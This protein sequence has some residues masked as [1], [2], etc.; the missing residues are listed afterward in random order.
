VVRKQ[1]FKRISFLFSCFLQDIAA[2]IKAGF[3]FIFR[4]YCRETETAVPIEDSDLTLAL[5]EWW[6]EGVVLCEL[7]LG[8]TKFTPFL[9]P[10][11]PRIV[12]NRWTAPLPK[13]LR[14]KK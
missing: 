2:E 3:C 1:L 10:L 9:T 11:P 13:L 5:S 14:N 12:T 6:W 8:V 7:D 4:Y